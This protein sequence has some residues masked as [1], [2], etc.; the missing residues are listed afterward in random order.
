MVFSYLRRL[1]RRLRSRIL[2]PAEV[3]LKETSARLGS[4]LQRLET[5]L[6]REND[7][8]RKRLDQ[9]ELLL[10][11]HPGVRLQDLEAGA[12]FP[13]PTVSIVMPT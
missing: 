2:W 1:A 13:S 9:L 3:H 6:L 4:D 11:E 7:R 10:T 12:R 8:L 5:L